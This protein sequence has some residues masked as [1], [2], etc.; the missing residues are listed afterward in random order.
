MK[1]IAVIGW[2]F[3]A[4]FCFFLSATFFGSF[5]TDSRPILCNS[6]PMQP[7]DVCIFHSNFS[8][9]KESHEQAEQQQVNP[10]DFEES[11]E[12][13]A[14]DQQIHPDHVPLDLFFAIFFA[15]LGVSCLGGSVFMA[16]YNGPLRWG[17]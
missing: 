9:T 16:K 3:A 12:Q 11:Y 1:V 10:P 7:G 14:Q 15:V 4:L 6:E 5:I 2:I 13:M 17:P 8:Q